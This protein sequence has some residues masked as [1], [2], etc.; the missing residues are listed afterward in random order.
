MVALA[1]KIEFEII[2]NCP[3]PQALA[4]EVLALKQ[5]TGAALNSCDRSPEAEPFLKRLGKMSQRQL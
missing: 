1:K 2:D 5:K 4:D 3:V